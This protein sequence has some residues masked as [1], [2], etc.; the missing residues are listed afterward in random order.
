MVLLGWLAILSMWVVPLV[1]FKTGD[2]EQTIFAQ[3]LIM[4]VSVVVIGIG[5]SLSY[6]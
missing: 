2:Y 1:M 5:V 6:S 4:L 3:M